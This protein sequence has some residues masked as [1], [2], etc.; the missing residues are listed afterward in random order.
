VDVL[1]PN[2]HRPQGFFVTVTFDDPDQAR[3]VF[4]VIETFKPGCLREVY[5]RFHTKG[6]MMPPGLNYIDSWL[7]KT[8]SRCF[9]LMETDDPKLFSEWTKHWEDV[10]HF[11]VI[12][13]GSKPTA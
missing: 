12:E 6:R 10:T 4:T 7:E 11:E 9:Q 1:P 3:R 2:F 8:G 5:E 13:I